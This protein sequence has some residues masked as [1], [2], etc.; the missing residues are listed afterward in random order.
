[1][2]DTTSFDP[3]TF[4]QSTV[5]A[6]LETEFKLCP[7]GEYQAMID[8]FTS[9]AFEQIDFE[10]KKGAKAGTPGTMLKLTIPFVIDSDKAKAEL[11]R[12]KV[13][14]TKQVILDRDQNGNLDFGTN[15]NI[16]LGRVRDAVG[17]NTPG[18]WAVS[19]LRGAGPVMVKVE[20]IEY[21]RNDGSKGKRAEVT[22]VVKLSR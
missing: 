22:R 4:M 19:K 15:K 10:Y 12:D 9:D 8:D 14:V 7:P 2:S 17:Q 13:T 6:P 1:M 16:E 18:P 11:N 21:K 3:D 5:D 20:H